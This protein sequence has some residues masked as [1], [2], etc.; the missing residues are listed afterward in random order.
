MLLFG[1]LALAL[2]ELDHLLEPVGQLVEHGEIHDIKFKNA[3]TDNPRP[4]YQGWA[5]HGAGQ[6]NVP[7]RSR[8]L[9]EIRPR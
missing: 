1:D 3:G 6:L 5:D 9:P 2:E 7:G 4:R 8:V